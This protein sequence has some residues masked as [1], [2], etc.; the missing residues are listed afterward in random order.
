M[1]AHLGVRYATVSEWAKAFAAT[2]L[3]MLVDKPRSGRPLLI[4]PA[5]RARLTALACSKA[6]DGHSQWS[7]RLLAGKSVELGLCARMSASSA[8]G[9]LKKTVVAQL[10]C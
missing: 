8:H 1:A 5:D 9:I 10:D 7:L 3:Q 6:P 4:Q 2:G